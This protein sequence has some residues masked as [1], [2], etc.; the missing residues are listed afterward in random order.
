MMLT[1]PDKYKTALAYAAQWSLS[2][3]GKGEHAICLRLLSEFST[4]RCSR[5]LREIDL[6]L[7]CEGTQ[8]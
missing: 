5:K 3:R 4:W 1:N 2:G 7:I 8:M 6:A